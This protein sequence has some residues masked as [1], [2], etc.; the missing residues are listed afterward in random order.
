MSEMTRP[1]LLATDLGPAGEVAA[2]RAIDLAVATGRP[3]VALHVLDLAG[4]PSAARDVVASI[5]EGAQARLSAVVDQAAKRGV[6]AKGD[7]REGRTAREIVRGVKRWHAALVAV[8][9]HAPN[10][11]GDLIVG[12]TLRRILQRVDCPVLV[13]QGKAKLPY[14]RALAMT[15]F[16]EHS[17][18]ALYGALPWLGKGAEV[19]V[20]HAFGVADYPVALPELGLGVEAIAALERLAARQVKDFVDGIRSGSVRLLP[21]VEVGPAAAVA[22]AI[23]QADDVPLVIVG[24]RGQG[25]VAAAMLGSTAERVLRVAGRD[26]LVVPA[27]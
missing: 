19:Q 13:P 25:R 14:A 17:V 23:A 12:T 15:D 8:G 18:A 1:I 6:D 10:P 11:V 26:V 16:S 4:L 5:R 22:R 21:R 9:P 7:L 3:L 20:L 24:S 2:Q 27:R